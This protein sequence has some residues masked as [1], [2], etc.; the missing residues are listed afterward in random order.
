[1][2][3]SQ[4]TVG[5]TSAGSPPFLGAARI[6]AQERHLGPDADSRPKARSRCLR[7]NC[8]RER[9]KEPVCA[10]TELISS[11]TTPG[12][13]KRGFLPADPLGMGDV[14]PQFLPDAVG[15]SLARQSLALRLT[16]GTPPIP[17]GVATASWSCSP[18]TP[19]TVF[20][21]TERPPRISGTM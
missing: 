6:G 1:V 2:T 17:T 11:Y 7:R 8:L 13:R 10:L 3:T 9:S 12:R 15:E 20:A 21:R 18:C 16:R 4:I 19:A 5:Y 14:T